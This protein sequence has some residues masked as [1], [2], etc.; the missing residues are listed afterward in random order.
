M[1]GI[2]LRSQPFK[3]KEIEEEIEELVEEAIDEV[4]EIEEQ[5]D[6]Q[7]VVPGQDIARRASNKAK[8]RNDLIRN[9]RKTEKL[10]KRMAERQ[11]EGRINELVRKRRQFFAD[12]NADIEAILT[13][14]L[15]ID[16]TIH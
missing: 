11:L 13:I 1:A 6:E 4:E 9:L 16:E 8:L 7:T 12:E 3:V 5:L 2:S 10:S 14:L 15:L